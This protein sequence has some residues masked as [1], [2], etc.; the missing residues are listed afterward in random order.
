SLRRWRAEQRSSRTVPTA[1]FRFLLFRA[2]NQLLQTVEFGIA[3]TFHRTLEQR[4]HQLRWR[5]AEEC[6]DHMRQRRLLRFF[7][8]NHW[9]VDVSQSL[10]VMPD[11]TLLL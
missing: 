9:L 11:V 5:P 8:R 2:L 10:L 7:R 1:S 3:H 4:C 6:R